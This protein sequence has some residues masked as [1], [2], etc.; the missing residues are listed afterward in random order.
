MSATEEALGVSEH[1]DHTISFHTERLARI[2]QTLEELR[3][4]VGLLTWENGSALEYRE[5]LE[6]IVQAVVDIHL[7]IPQ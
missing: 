3:S 2:R 1:D 5:R 4:H 7:V 6:E